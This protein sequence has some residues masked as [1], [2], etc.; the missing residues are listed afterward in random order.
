MCVCV[1][2]RAQV[3]VCVLCISTYYTLGIEEVPY[4]RGWEVQKVVVFGTVKI[5]VCGASEDPDTD[6][7]LYSVS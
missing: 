5:I 3:C 4:F 7:P 1:C 6:V 2:V